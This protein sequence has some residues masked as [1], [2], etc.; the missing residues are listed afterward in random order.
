VNSGFFSVTV[1]VRSAGV[2][3]RRPAETNEALVAK[4]QRG[5]ASA[6]D[7]LVRQNVGL[8]AKQA[9][10]FVRRCRLLE[11]DDLIAEGQMGLLCAIDKF[12]PS[13]GARFSSYADRWI[14]QRMMKALADQDLRIPIPTDVLD[15]IRYVSRKSQRLR[16]AG[17]DQ[18]AI[19]TRLLESWPARTLDLARQSEL[20]N[21]GE[22]LDAPFA[23]GAHADRGPATLHDVLA[24]PSVDIDGRER[25]GWIRSRVDA[26]R[27]SLS[28]REIEILD[29]RL[30]PSAAKEMLSELAPRLGISRQRVK[31][32]EERL[33]RRLRDVLESEVD[34]ALLNQSKKPRNARGAQGMKGCDER[35]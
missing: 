19:D 11:V 16:Q 21:R 13:K 29:R 23:A 31:Q 1:G 25:D 2:S 28:P 3:G 33:I 8:V 22:S 26:L 32:L 14:C 12:D 34:P 24:G 5:D 30:M 17:L 10:R 7:R 20:V 15:T 4:A 18:E 9:Y 6:R 27:P 35:S